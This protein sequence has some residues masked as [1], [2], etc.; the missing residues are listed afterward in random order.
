[1]SF[2]PVV[3]ACTVKSCRT[4]LTGTCSPSALTLS[5]HSVYRHDADVVASRKVSLLSV[6]VMWGVASIRH[7]L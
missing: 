3:L 7:R 6:A 1:M 5:N 4:S 2:G